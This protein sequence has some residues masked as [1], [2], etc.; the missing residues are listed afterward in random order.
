MTKVQLAKRHTHAG[1]VYEADTVLEVTEPEAD[2]LKANGVA[3]AGNKKTRWLKP[4]P[5]T[6]DEDTDP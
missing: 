1:V 5:D 3:L 4:V 2:W 6:P